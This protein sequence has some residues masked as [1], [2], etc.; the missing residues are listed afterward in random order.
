M[1]ASATARAAAQA[2]RPGRL[3]G[4][5]SQSTIDVAN[6]IAASGVWMNVE[7]DSITPMAMAPPAI[8]AARNLGGMRKL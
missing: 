7:D 6:G 3:P 8:K 4:S 5:P 1:T 2:L